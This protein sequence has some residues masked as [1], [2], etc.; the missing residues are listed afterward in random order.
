MRTHHALTIAALAVSGLTFLGCD[1]DQTASKTQTTVTRTDT[2]TGD[3]AGAKTDRALNRAGD[4]VSNAAD[5]TGDALGRAV[6][7]TTDTARTAADKTASAIGRA[8]ASTQPAGAAIVPDLDKIRVVIADTVDDALTRNHFDNLVD[9]FTKGDRDRLSKPANNMMDD[10]N[11]Q[12]DQ[13]NSAWKAKYNQDFD[14]KAHRE[15]VFNSQF[16]MINEGALADT[17]RLAASKT[18][19]GAPA[20]GGAAPTGDASIDSANSAESRNTASVTIPA[21]HGL[22]QV[23]LVL[24]NEGLLRGYKIDVADK[25]DAQKLHDNLLSQVTAINADK[26]NWPADVNDAY[27]MVAH[28]VLMALQDAPSSESS[29]ASAAGT[30]R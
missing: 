2:S 28:R 26:A 23:I 15:N 5:K 20:A 8:T 10:I 19:T 30:A 24:N 16:A 11:A 17:A 1:K 21:S 4:A 12:V 22:G 3:T 7:K 18:G 29:G 9:R 6:D 13:I 14:I 27:R 25:L